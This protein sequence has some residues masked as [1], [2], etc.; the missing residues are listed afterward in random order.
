MLGLQG[1]ERQHLRE[2]RAAGHAG[3]QVGD[4]AA[5]ALWMEQIL[6]RGREGLVDGR[7]F[8]GGP[9]AREQP[10]REPSPAGRRPAHVLRG[11]DAL[12]RSPRMVPTN[13]GHQK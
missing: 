2:D 13:T 9:G 8:T 4:R 12:L 6:D 3:D 5:A 7:P 1:L 10:H 11:E